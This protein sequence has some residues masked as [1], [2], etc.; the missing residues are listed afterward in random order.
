MWRTIPAS[1]EVMRLDLS[2]DFCI[3]LPKYNDLLTACLWQNP[4]PSWS[5]RKDVL[6]PAWLT[7]GVGPS[8]LLR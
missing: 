4:H 3:L 7:A 5:Q 6:R 2:V 1:A 8:W